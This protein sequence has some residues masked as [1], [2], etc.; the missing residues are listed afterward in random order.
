MLLSP[1]HC[2]LAEVRTTWLAGECVF[3]IPCEE[4]SSTCNFNEKSFRR[5]AGALQTGLSEKQLG[6]IKCWWWHFAIWIAPFIMA[7][8]PH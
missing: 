7:N 4:K 5:T 3:I 1:P 6:L 2:L 8:G